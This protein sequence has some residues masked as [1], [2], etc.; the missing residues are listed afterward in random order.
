MLNLARSVAP[1]RGLD[2]PFLVGRVRLLHEHA[3][4]GIIGSLICALVFGAACAGHGAPTE[5][6]IWTA[7]FAGLSAAR[8]WQIRRFLHCEDKSP[9]AAR[10]WGAQFLVFSLA[11]GLWWGYA[12]IVLVEGQPEVLRL[13]TYLIIG[14]L[15]AG[16]VAAFAAVLPVF[17]A[18]TA[19]ALGPLVIQL[20]LFG[21]DRVSYLVGFLIL[22]F[23]LVLSA[24]A[25]KQSETIRASL[26][27][28]FENQELIEGLQSAMDDSAAL[29]DSLT[30]EI[31]QRERIEQDLA[32][33]LALY[34]ATMDAVDEGILALDRD[35]R[36]VA[37]N[38]RFKALWALNDKDAATGADHRRTAERLRR[39]QR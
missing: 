14:G 8:L 17:F 32:R 29:N 15:C 24:T 20:V 2:Q 7:G 21:G 5:L 23:L 10:R 37:I 38:K 4:F 39:L 18:F 31:R 1:S 35:H 9:E 6:S 19:G 25:V 16:S 11:S 3:G 26:Q 28:Q 34:Q 30:A 13:F 22:V 33:S 27:I 36:I 12:G